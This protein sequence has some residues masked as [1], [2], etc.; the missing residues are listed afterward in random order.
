MYIVDNV[1]LE[2]M[3]NRVKKSENMSLLLRL[4]LSKEHKCSIIQAALLVI[5]G[6]GQ[7]LQSPFD[8]S[9]LFGEEL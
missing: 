3:A 4:I 2:L 6:L 7:K 5:M 9:M 8:I 1:V